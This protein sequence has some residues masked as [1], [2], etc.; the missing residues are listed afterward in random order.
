MVK[1]C[2]LD[3]GPIEILD[4]RPCIEDDGGADRCAGQ[5]AEERE[6]CQ[7]KGAETLAHKLS[8]RQGVTRRAPCGHHRTGHRAMTPLESIS[9]LRALGR[10]EVAESRRRYVDARQSSCGA[11]RVWEEWGDNPRGLFAR[12]VTQYADDFERRMTDALTHYLIARAIAK[13]I[14]ALQREHVAAALARLATYSRDFGDYADREDAV[15]AR[16]LREVARAK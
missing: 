8:R 3:E 4:T 5:E 7:P 9:L 13:A 12:S 1:A 2:T 10:I 11:T 14:G 16:A 15:R 6:M